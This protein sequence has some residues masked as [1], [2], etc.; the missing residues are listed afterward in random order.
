VPIAWQ[1]SIAFITKILYAIT[2]LYDCFLLKTEDV[3]RND[4]LSP[5]SLLLCNNNKMHCK[6]I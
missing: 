2:N 3:L 4:S 5:Y 6:W 1:Q